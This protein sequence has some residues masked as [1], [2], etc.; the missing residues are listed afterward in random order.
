[1]GCDAEDIALTI[2]AHPTLHESVGLAAKYLKV[3]LQTYQMRKPKAL[4][5]LFNLKISGCIFCK[6][7]KI[8]LLL[9]IFKTKLLNSEFFF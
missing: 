6:F 1:M 4:I 2:H 8:Q 7:F 3:Q 5:R 9:I